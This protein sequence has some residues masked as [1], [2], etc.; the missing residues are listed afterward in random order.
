MSLQS[1][2]QETV[3]DYEKA[4]IP[5]EVASVKLKEKREYT[6]SAEAIGVRFD[7]FYDKNGSELAHLYW[8][9]DSFATLFFDD[10]YYFVGDNIKAKIDD[11]EEVILK[12]AT[13][14]SPTI[15]YLYP[16]KKT[17]EKVFVK[18]CTKHNAGF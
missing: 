10:N 4:L 8:T 1:S 3:I 2:A 11:M 7:Y 14:E 18:S 17:V 12:C 16:V 9:G 15:I 13:P 5:L 6:A